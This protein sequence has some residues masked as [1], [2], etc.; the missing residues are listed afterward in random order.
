M[1]NYAFFLFIDMW[2]REDESS[3]NFVGHWTFS[4][5]KLLK[6]ELD[7][8]FKIRRL[9]LKQEHTFTKKIFTETS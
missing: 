1:K 8:N 6:Y 2:L 4:G 5:K 3:D 7:F 9:G